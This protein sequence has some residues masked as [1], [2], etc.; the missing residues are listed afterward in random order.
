MNSYYKYVLLCSPFTR[1]IRCVAERHT[2]PLCDISREQNHVDLVH[3]FPS[4]PSNTK[5]GPGSN[6][7]LDMCA[8]GNWLNCFFYTQFETFNDWIN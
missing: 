3:S 6:F 1:Q 5:L 4:I 8:I 7:P 2:Q